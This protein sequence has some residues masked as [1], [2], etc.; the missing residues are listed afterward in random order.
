VARPSTLTS[1]EDHRVAGLVAAG[2]AVVVWGSSSVL[3]KNIDGMSGLAIAFHR[4]WIGAV[5]TVAAYLLSG[6]RFTLHLLWVSLPGGIA[7]SLD[8]V[9]FFSALKH[10]SV[11]NATIIGALQP[12]LILAI[13]HRLFGERPHLRDAFWASVAIAGAVIV[14]AGAPSDGDATRAGD[15]LAVG[16]LFAWTW[17]FI[18]S[19]RVRVELGSF[20]YLAGLSVIAVGVVTPIVFV[21]REPIA[22]P[23][24]SSWLTIV[25]IA[26]LNGAVGHFLMNW[27]H[28]HVP[29]VVVSLM[30]LAIP[31]FATVTAAIFIDEPVSVAQVVGMAIVIAALSF[32]VVR[33]S[34]V[35]PE[36][37]QAAEVAEPPGA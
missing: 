17:Y 14:V 16:A 35:A 25:L 2:T 7:F 18:A 21:S 9:L 29:I 8:I 27:A 32:V 12:V 26:V 33:T 23:N 31:V 1:D 3:V 15:L 34:S 30:T 11:A 20:D 13:A 6:R 4:L 19:K 36:T 28:G 24:L 22:V 10:T 5:L 37:A